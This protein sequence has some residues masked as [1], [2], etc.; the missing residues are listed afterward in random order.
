MPQSYQWAVQAYRTID[1]LRKNYTQFSLV[2]SRK[3]MDEVAAEAT[4]WMRANAPWRDRPDDIKAKQAPSQYEKTHHARQEL[5]A[6][7]V[8]N[9]ENVKALSEFQ[10]R[11]GAAKKI[12]TA[13]LK[14]ENERLRRQHIENLRAQEEEYFTKHGESLDT[15]SHSRT[16]EQASYQKLKILPPEQSA[17]LAYQQ[18]NQPNIIP[19]GSLVLRYRNP[20]DLTY[21]IWLEV[22][23]G[24]RY[25]IIAPAIAYWYPKTVGKVKQMLNL[26]QYRNLSI[27]EQETDILQRLAFPESYFAQASARNAR[28]RSV[29]EY[30]PYGT[31]ERLTKRSAN[32][33]TYRKHGRV[34]YSDY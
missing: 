32:K 27:T 8:D 28:G 25:S 10:A 12:D 30:R 18:N 33:R 29:P 13:R 16:K 20:K 15:I 17:A 6:V 5:E 11:L 19:I 26:V 3:A 23:M 34:T 2:V 4:A 31:P 24:G 7:A 22:G 21:A 9:P 1:E 14:A